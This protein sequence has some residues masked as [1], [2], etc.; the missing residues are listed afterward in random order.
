MPEVVVG[1]GVLRAMVE[2][3]SLLGKHVKHSP[4]FV[5]LDTYKWY[6]KADNRR[7]GKPNAQVY[8]GD[9]HPDV[10]EQDLQEPFEKFGPIRYAIQ[11]EARH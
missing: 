11:K 7:G 9:L 4:N 3:V 1:R 6:F 5:V 8:I 10:T 2:E